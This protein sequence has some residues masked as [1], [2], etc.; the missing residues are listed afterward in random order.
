ML[1]GISANVAETAPD[2]AD[3]RLRGRTY[4][5]PFEE[6]WQAALGLAQARNRM[7]QV[8]LADDHDGVLQVEARSLIFRRMADFEVRIGLDEDGQTR[9]DVRSASRKGFADLGGNARRI[10][11]FL[12][13]L[14]KT[15]KRNRQ[16]RSAAASPA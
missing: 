11:R 14:D 9:V 1:R 7:W 3:P 4:A 16:K 2:D 5:V 8:T 12:R 6:V 10:G 15:L 13:K